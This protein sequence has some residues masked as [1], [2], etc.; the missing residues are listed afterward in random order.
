MDVSGT[1]LHLD[2]AG[3]A[4][5]HRALSAR[6]VDL[7][8][9]QQRLAEVVRAMLDGWRGDAADAFR[10]HWEDWRDGAEGVVAAL[11]AR[12]DAVDLACA[13]LDASDAA[14][15]VS[16]SRLRGRLG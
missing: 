13:D 2:R 10:G 14:S 12:L 5:R 9:E 1:T 6:A 11:G 15:A 3:V 8:D 7:A 4:A 16:S